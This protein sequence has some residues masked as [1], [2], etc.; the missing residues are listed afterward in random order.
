MSKLIHITLMKVRLTM[1][2]RG[3]FVW[4]FLAPIIF[5]AVMILVFGSGNTGKADA[6]YP[7]SIVDEDKGPNAATFIKLLNQDKTFELIHSDE[8]KARLDIQNGKTVL[9][10]VIPEGFSQS[11]N[12]GNSKKLGVLRLQD[13]DN[14]IAL[15]AIVENYIYQLK[16]GIT[17]GNES[18]AQLTSRNLIKAGES[19]TISEKVKAAF[20]SAME[21]QE[22][23][24]TVNKLNS[25]DLGLNALSSTAI[26]VFVM[27]I[28][29]FVTGGAGNILEEIETGTWSRLLSTPTRTSSILG[30]YIL[31]TFLLG[32][33][34]TGLLILVSRFVFHVNWGNSPLGLFL[35]FS[36]F[37]LAVIGLG[38][39]LAAFVKSRG[40]LSALTAIIVMPTSL[41]AGCMWPRDLMPETVQKIADFVPQSW[42]LKGMTDLVAR[43]SDISSVYFPSAILLLFTFVFF[44]AGSIF[45]R[46][47]SWA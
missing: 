4:M 15:M 29:F 47:R 37:L 24:Y 42:V 6:K 14:T 46:Q 7:I 40:Q 44:L 33:I 25:A 30:G 5:A 16:L 3:A 36:S 43:G 32:W 21:S 34:Q 27:F 39:A 11:V 18:A 41:I 13:N 38:T 12:E 2:D 35:L 19:Q 8:Q 10:I 20:L 22:I 45:L 1:R 17:A 23:G 28:M 26:G 31:G 9:G